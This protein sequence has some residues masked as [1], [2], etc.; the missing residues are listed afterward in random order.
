MKIFVFNDKTV[1]S[2]VSVEHYFRFWRQEES[3]EGEEAHERVQLRSE[4][5]KQSPQYGNINYNSSNNGG[6]KYH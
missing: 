5:I 4:L 6:K 2:D 1:F 3:S